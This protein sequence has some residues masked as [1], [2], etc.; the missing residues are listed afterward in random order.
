MEKILT[1]LTENELCNVAGGVDLKKLRDMAIIDACTIA[2][3]V[4]GIASWTCLANEINKKTDH[5]RTLELYGTETSLMDETGAKRLAL[6]QFV[7]L[8]MGATSGLCLG[9]E[10][11]E[12]LNKK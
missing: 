1:P 6:G 8:A 10:I 5:A 2:G 3:S 12:H 4:A 7:G 11:V 9:K